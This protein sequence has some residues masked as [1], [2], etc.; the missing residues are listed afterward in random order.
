VFGLT[1]LFVAQRDGAPIAIIAVVLAVLVWIA[2]QRLGYAEFAEINEALKRVFF[3]Q[4]RVIQHNLFIRKLAD[5]LRDATSLDNACDLLAKA[6]EQLGFSHLMLRCGRPGALP[7]AIEG[8]RGMPDL[9]RHTVMSVVLAGHTGEVG[10]VVLARAHK[11]APLHSTLPVFIDTITSTL[12]AI[13]EETLLEDGA[14]PHEAAHTI[15]VYPPPNGHRRRYDGRAL[16]ASLQAIPRRAAVAA[17]PAAARAADPP[18][19]S[20]QPCP[21]CD[22]LALAR[23]HSRTLAERVRKLLSSRRLHRCS[24]CGWRG[25]V[26]VLIPLEHDEPRASQPV[27][28]LSSLD[29]GLGHAQAMRVA[30]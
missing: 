13:V 18:M 26:F 21:Q 1:S 30:L 11:A 29:H 12:P 27:P 24:E 22:A 19:L 16:V 3:Y 23:S 15:R 5:D 20:S 10:E 25:W 9:R 8:V 4:R 2:L 7:P 14:R 28:D 17:M 6:A